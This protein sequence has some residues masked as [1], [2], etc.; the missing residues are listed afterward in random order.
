MSRLNVTNNKSDSN[1]SYAGASELLQ[2]REQAQL[3]S[4]TVHQ[5]QV[6]SLEPGALRK[7]SDPTT[8]RRIAAPMALGRNR[9]PSYTPGTQH[10]AASAAAAAAAA[11]SASAATK[12]AAS[13]SSQSP[14]SVFLSPNDPVDQVFRAGAGA[15]QRRHTTLTAGLDRRPS[16]AGAAGARQQRA[17]SRAV[18]DIAPAEAETIVRR[19]QSVA[20]AS[21]RR[22]SICLS[23]RSRRMLLSLKELNRR[24]FA[25]KFNTRRQLSDTYRE[26][27]AAER[28]EARPLSS[29]RL[30]RRAL[31]LQM[32]QTTALPDSFL[33]VYS[34]SD[35]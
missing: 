24:K 17:H 6:P 3:P 34:I 16:A 5:L 2:R 4:T 11:V 29:T 18:F 19:R 26:Q 30:G 10:S 15:S 25:I 32:V 35:R 20:S 12:S 7:H 33:V 21:K 8:S 23:K 27:L 14:G 31:L 13:E 9:T 22:Q 28:D 1:I